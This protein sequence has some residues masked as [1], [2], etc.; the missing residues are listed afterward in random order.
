MNR[1]AIILVLA[2]MLCACHGQR[3]ASRSSAMQQHTEQTADTT[4]T[5][6]SV[7]S[8]AMGADSLGLLFSA[9]SIRTPDGAVIYRPQLSAA[10]T[11]PRIVASAARA[12]SAAAHA[13]T[14]TDAA[15]TAEEKTEAEAG[16][17]TPS[18]SMGTILA[19]LL[20]IGLISYIFLKKWLKI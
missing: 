10:V 16:A 6:R 7:L 15:A 5:H 2:A 11:A 20:A 12:D 18:A 19:I 17:L 9:D 4:A 1:A 3:S 14:A 8:L 13:T